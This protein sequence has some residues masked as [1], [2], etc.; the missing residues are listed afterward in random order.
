MGSNIRLIS[1]SIWQ[2]WFDEAWCEVI[3]LMNGE[4]SEKRGEEHIA[5]YSI[6]TIVLGYKLMD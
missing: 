1:F 2:K 5:S 4:R 6:D 3:A